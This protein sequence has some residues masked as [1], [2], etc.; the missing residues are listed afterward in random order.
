M[1]TCTYR[2]TALALDGLHNHPLHNQPTNQPPTNQ[3]TAGHAV[4]GHA[5]NR[6]QHPPLQQ[7]PSHTNLHCSTHSLLTYQSTNINQSTIFLQLTTSRPTNPPQDMAC[8]TFLKIC[9]KCRRKFV[10]L[11]LQEREPFVCELLGHL[12]ETINDLQA[13]QVSCV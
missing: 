11:Q 4:A 5:A 7:V 13:H 10:V 3:P 12:A 8:D 2:Y 1:A 9:S 6:M